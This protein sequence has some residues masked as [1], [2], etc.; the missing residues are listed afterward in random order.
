MERG[1][2]EGTRRWGGQ[3]G[4]SSGGHGGGWGGQQQ[5]EKIRASGAASFHGKKLKANIIGAF[6][7]NSQALLSLRARTS[8]RGCSSG[9]PHLPSVRGATGWYAKS[10]GP[11]NR[12]R[13][14][15]QPR[16]V[17]GLECAHQDQFAFLD[18]HKLTME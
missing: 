11:E 7:T 6:A 15:F 16:S 1:E 2:V 3:R 18:V 5:D 17:V 14:L 8:R 4:T 10:N 9:V 12:V 13:V